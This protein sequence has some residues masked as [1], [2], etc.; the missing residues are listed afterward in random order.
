[1]SHHPTS[2]TGE[3]AKVRQQTKDAEPIA[4]STQ[5]SASVLHHS[6]APGDSPV[7]AKPVIPT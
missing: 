2:A 4:G 6:H 5:K 1:M 3:A 7:D